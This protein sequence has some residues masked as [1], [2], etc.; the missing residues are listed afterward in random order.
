MFF[1]KDWII[2]NM[3]VFFLEM[4][5]YWSN[6]MGQLMFVNKF[7]GFLKEL[8]IDFEFIINLLMKLNE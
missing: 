6:F 3:V 1:L 7:F 2:V 8:V 5:F 4:F